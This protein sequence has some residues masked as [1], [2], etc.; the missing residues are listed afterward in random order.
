MDY[1]VNRLGAAASTDRLMRC[2]AFWEQLDENC[3]RSAHDAYRRLAHRWLAVAW[4]LW[5]SSETYCETYHLGQRRL[6]NRP[7]V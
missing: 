6:Y 3:A 4:K 7:R 1:A 2:L 5:Q